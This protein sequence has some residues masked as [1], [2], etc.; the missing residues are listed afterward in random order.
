MNPLKTYQEHFSGLQ[1]LLGNYV[2]LH[3]AFVELVSLKMVMLVFSSFRVGVQSSCFPFRK[4]ER[5]MHICSLA[6]SVYMFPRPTLQTLRSLRWSDDKLCG[7]KQ[8]DTKL[9]ENHVFGYIIIIWEN[10][11]GG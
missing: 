10:K 9:S 3:F 7:P 5:D 2:V 4:D 6:L 11:H 1:D 8:T